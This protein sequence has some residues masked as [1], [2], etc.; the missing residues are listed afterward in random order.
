MA[1]FEI[2]DWS[3]RDHA[4]FRHLQIRWRL[5]SGWREFEFSFPDELGEPTSEDLADAMLPLSLFTA[6]KHGWSLSLPQP[7][8]AQLLARQPGTQEI[9]ASWFH[10][11]NEIPVSASP[12]TLSFS[13]GERRPGIAAAFTSGVDSLLTALDH[14]E[15]LDFLV[16]VQG[17]GPP[18]EL[19]EGSFAQEAAHIRRVAGRLGLPWHLVRTT[20]RVGEEICAPWMENH[21]AC[22]AALGLMLGNRIGTFLLPSSRSW[23]T[24]IPW[25]SS[26]WLDER[27]STERVRIRLD[28]LRYSRVQKLARMVKL[29]PEFVPEILVCVGDASGST[30]L[31]CGQCEK[32]LRTM[33]CLALS[34]WEQ[35]EG[36][37]KQPLDLDR[38]GKLKIIGPPHQD[39]WRNI[40]KYGEAHVPNHP[41]VG[42]LRQVAANIG[43]RKLLKL[44]GDHDGE[45]PDGPE[46]AKFCRVLRDDLW[47]SWSAHQ[48]GWLRKQMLSFAESRPAQVLKAV[49]GKE[50][51]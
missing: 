9:A 29:Y 12:R 14:R 43:M 40:L 27:W 51:L 1:D 34:G 50:T 3:V 38:V 8:S 15:E 49:F 4:G 22:L 41:V 47:Q 20:Y 19:N 39:E 42:A 11:F 36:V 26:H 21:G 48:G 25:G 23:A 33:C 10:G 2:F 16:F 31:N 37:F 17:Y 5:P 13:G 6:M 18:D 46:L 35:W 44:V 32:C 7:V 28:A 30:V 45:L 24:Q